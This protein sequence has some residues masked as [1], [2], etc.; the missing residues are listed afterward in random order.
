M[1]HARFVLFILFPCLFVLLTHDGAQGNGGRAKPEKYWIGIEFT[2]QGIRPS[3]EKSDSHVWFSMS[4]D[5][6]TFLLTSVR[7][8][9][10][11]LRIDVENL[12]DKNIELS[13]KDDTMLFEFLQDGDFKDVQG[14]LD[15]GKQDP[16]FW[17]SLDVEMRRVLVYDG[18][19]MKGETKTVFVFIPNGEHLKSMPR[20]VKYKI[21]SLRQWDPD[22]YSGSRYGGHLK[23]GISINH[24]SAYVTGK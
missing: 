17:D 8:K 6:P 9:Y 21:E 10:K 22:V 3:P 7:G 13:S 14:I 20:R 1:R 18:L 5:K 12:C 23:Q 15:V 11:L 19:L 4:M 2:G 24:S 16:E